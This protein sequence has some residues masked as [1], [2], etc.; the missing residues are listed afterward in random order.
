MGNE[1]DKE[2]DGI[3]Y[4]QRGAWQYFFLLENAAYE[5]P[6]FKDK[7]GQCKTAPSRKE[8]HSFR[9]Y[10]SPAHG[11]PSLTFILLALIFDFYSP[12]F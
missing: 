8:I 6:E 4:H 3:P 10:S 11:K 5:E 12:F 2:R 1:I 7:L 9:C